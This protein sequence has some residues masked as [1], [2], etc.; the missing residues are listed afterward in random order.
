MVFFGDF[1]NERDVRFQYLNPR[2]FFQL[3]H[4]CF[5]GG[6]S[7]FLPSAGEFPEMRGWF[8]WVQYQYNLSFWST[9]KYKCCPIN[10]LVV[11]LAPPQKSK[12]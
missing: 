1:R 7:M 2:F 6:F 8:F 11:H 12:Y 5:F 9:N 3:T 4:R 10:C